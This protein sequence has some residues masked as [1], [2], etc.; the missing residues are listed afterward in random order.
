MAWRLNSAQ[1][2]CN[3]DKFWASLEINFIRKTC[4]LEAETS[5]NGLTWCLG[6]TSDIGVENMYA[7]KVCLLL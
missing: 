3:N 1:N 4:T 5:A 2:G 7:L 6:F